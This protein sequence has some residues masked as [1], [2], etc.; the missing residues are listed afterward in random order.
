[1]PPNSYIRLYLELHLKNDQPELLQ[2]L[3]N[4]LQ[5]GL[6]S[7]EY[8]RELCQNCLTCSLPVRN[9]PV[10][11]PTQTQPEL[12][13]TSP[14]ISPRQQPIWVRVIQSLKDEFTVRWLLLLGIFL[15][16]I[17]SAVLAASGWQEFSDT[18]QYIILFLYSLGFW[19]TGTWL[20]RL[21]SIPLTALT[22]Q[23]IAILLIPVN[24]WG[25]DTF[26]L[27]L[28][29]QGIIVMA[30]ASLTLTGI[31][32]WQNRQQQSLSSSL[33]Y[34]TLCFL[35]LGW[36]WQRF[37]LIA[38]YVGGIITFI[39]LQFLTPRR[40]IG[41][42]FIVYAFVLI[43]I[44]GV[45]IV[46]LPLSEL[47]VIFGL[48]GWLI[49]KRRL[50]R[51]L[52]KWSPIIGFSLLLI[53]LIVTLRQELPWQAFI[54]LI[55]GIQRNFIYLKRYWQR[56]YLLAIFL[57][58]LQLFFLV[59]KFMPVEIK[60]LVSRLW[61]SLTQPNGYYVTIY[62][63][64]ILI[65]LAVFLVFL[66]WI[67][68]KNQAKVALFGERLCLILGLIVFFIA[69]LNPLTQL[70]N[71]ILNTIILT[72]LA[73]RRT[74][75]SFF[76]VNFAHLAGLFSILA[77]IDWQLPYLTHSQ[78]VS[79]FLGIMIIEWVTSAIFAQVT[80]CRD[81]CWFMGLILAGCSYFIILARVETPNIAALW[82]VTPLTITGII[83]RYPQAKR[84][85]MARISSLALLIAQLLCIWFA[86]TRIIGFTVAT[87]LMIVNYKYLPRQNTA[88]LH[89][90]FILGL[91][92]SIVGVILNISSWWLPAAIASGLLWLVVEYLRTKYPIY[93][94]S[95]LFWA[96]GLGFTLLTLLSFRVILI[97]F[98]LYSANWQS[99]TAIAI[100]I[101]SLTIWYRKENYS[102][103]ILGI[104]WLLELGLIETNLLLGGNNLTL[105][106]ANV[107]LGLLSL[108][109][110]QWLGNQTPKLALIPLFY[111]SIALVLR[112]GYFTPYTGLLTLGIAGI[113]VGVTTLRREWKPF[114]YISV[115]GISLGIYES[116]FYQL[117][118][119]SREAFLQQLTFIAIVTGLIAI[120]YRL[121]GW[122]W[123]ESLF[124]LSSRDIITLADIHWGIATGIQIIIF[125]QRQTYTEFNL[126]ILLL[127][128][129][130]GGY[131]LIQ[132]R[133]QNFWVYIGITQIVSG[134][135]Y[136]RLSWQF[137][138]ILDSFLLILV[139]LVALLSYRIPWSRWGWNDITCKN[140]VTLAPALTASLSNPSYLD[141]IIVAIFYLIL[142]REQQNIR[143]S[144]FSLGFLLW[145][146]ARWLLTQNDVDLLW[147]VTIIGLGINY[148]AA[149]DPYL[150]LPS[151]K[152][153]RHQLR[154]LGSGII[155]IVAIVLHQETGI[156]PAGLGLL[157]MLLG[158]ALKIRAF[159]FIG[160]LTFTVTIFYQLIILS[161]TYSFLKWIVGL[162]VGIGLIT[163][164]ANFERSRG[165]MSVIWQQWLI[166]LEQWE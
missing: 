143:Y 17:S 166:Q 154:L 53:G 47:G 36:D 62:S 141:L 134:I 41:V 63:V 88:I 57:L 27:W 155:A 100:L 73:Y 40:Q 102:N 92:G 71:L 109:L 149:V 132:G 126:L 124:N 116:L 129:L 76:R 44:R 85:N 49:S 162:V 65:Y 123:R 159:L 52:K 112:L 61:Y 80:L 120:A 68:R 153:Q 29:T 75:T 84:E 125:L 161:F 158:L 142:A 59:D 95:A 140:G 127:S 54:I 108:T 89:Y 137:S 117:L 82:L 101:I 1:M 113:G 70:Y 130:L 2:G 146:I 118:P 43:L 91:I 64:S 10:I 106:T 96:K 35:H 34:L 4:W 7:E 31:Y 160:T 144:Y 147:Y 9:I 16:I 13:I 136:L 55:L 18:I 119:I 48:M 151:Q 51:L 86:N 148:I 56:G 135:I 37:P 163:I 74:P 115:L 32:L 60:N 33:N 66:D 30:I 114:T 5:L 81:S 99:L 150:Q 79:I 25:M 3:D 97:S 93:A 22:L 128:L 83:S 8:V 46:Q 77:I 139:C 69:C 58:S 6:I 42:N 38:I 133:L 164:A 111:A 45:F 87:A 105:A 11:Q 131:A 72:Y 20:R 165:Q 50:Q 78:W 157:A 110:R 23:T 28:D 90:G 94:Q 21:S 122:L 14:A 67:Y 107:I 103:L 24:F 98:S 39:V 26:N 152:K 138:S 12:V 19:I 145:A 15:V 104:G 121:G 156:I